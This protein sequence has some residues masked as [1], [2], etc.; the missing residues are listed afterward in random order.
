ML[1]AAQYGKGRVRIM[2]LTRN[3]DHHT[4]RELDLTVLMRGSFDAAT[5][6]RAPPTAIPSRWTAT[7]AASSSSMPR[8]TGRFCARGCAATRS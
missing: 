6:S 7:A 2:R 4:P 1:K 3:G 8:G 5:P